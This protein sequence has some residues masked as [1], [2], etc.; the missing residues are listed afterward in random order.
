MEL[1]PYSVL[2]YSDELHFGSS[3]GSQPVPLSPS[4]PDAPRCT[5]SP[6]A[7]GSHTRHKPP[8]P[9]E[10]HVPHIPDHR[11]NTQ[12]GDGGRNSDSTGPQLCRQGLIG[13]WMTVALEVW[14][15]FSCC[16]S[17]HH[18]Q[19]SPHEGQCSTITCYSVHLAPFTLGYIPNL[20]YRSGLR[21]A[22]ALAP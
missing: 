15:G 21:A 5:T 17:L 9:R 14:H 12:G 20:G 7:G 6:S 18:P 4:A 3:K 22:G 2:G 11:G 16:H 19:L 10:Y 1:Q 13:T 8:G